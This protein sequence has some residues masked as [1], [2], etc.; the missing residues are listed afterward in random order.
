MAKGWKVIKS[1]N[2]GSLILVYT[3]KGYKRYP[4]GI[5]IKPEKGWG[6]LCVFGYHYQLDA[7]NFATHWGAK[8][9]PCTYTPSKHQNIWKKSMVDFSKG[10]KDLNDLPFGTRLAASV[11]CL[12]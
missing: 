8:V 9:V 3:E 12:E 1:R 4:V 11:T 5:K 10:S 6:P 7:E 2:R